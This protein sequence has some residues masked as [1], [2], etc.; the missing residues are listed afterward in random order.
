MEKENKTLKILLIVFVVA[1]LLLGGFIVYDKVLKKDENISKEI[2]SQN[3]KSENKLEENDSS[4]NTFSLDTSKSYGGSGKVRVKGYPSIIQMPTEACY[5]DNC[6]NIPT[7]DY[8]M[9][10]V[11]ET[12][13][14]DFIKYI[15]ESKGNWF[16]DEDA[17]G[18][19]CLKNN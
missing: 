5:S 19:G 14:D 10:K 18:I 17:I 11:I 12:N 15:K 16:F 13:N 6:E 7:Q 3:N 9:F 4:T 1:T 2:E 8:V